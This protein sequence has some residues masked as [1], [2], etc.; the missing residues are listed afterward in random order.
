MEE[1]SGRK[2]MYFRTCL[3]AGYVGFVIKFISA[4]RRRAEYFS[5]TIAMTLEYKLL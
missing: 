1:L 3:K 4:L 2:L 5:K